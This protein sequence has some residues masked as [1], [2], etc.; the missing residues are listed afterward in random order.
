MSLLAAPVEGVRPRIDRADAGAERGTLAATTAWAG[1]CALVMV[2]PFEALR[3]LVR[4]PG[5]TLTTVEAAMLLVIA[6]WAVAMALA[7]PPG[8]TEWGP[9]VGPAKPGRYVLARPWLA[10]VGAMAIA[11]LAAPAHVAN[12]LHMTGRAA[13]ALVVYLVTV[14]GV[15]SAARRRAVLVSMAAAAG[16]VAALVVGEYAGVDGVVRV[17]SAFRERTA[18]VGAQVRASGPLQYP[19]IASF[20]LEIGFAAV[21]ALVL[22]SADAGRRRAAGAGALLAVLVGQAIVLTFTRA[23]LVTMASTLAIVGAARWRRHGWDRGA[24]VLVVIGLAIAALFLTSR[25]LESLRLRLTTETMD[26]WYRAEIAAPSHVVMQ[27]GGGA[28]V[29]VTLTNIGS[30]TWDSS[31]APPFRFSYHWLLAGE[32]TIVQWDGLRT[33][34][35]VPVAPGASVSLKAAVRAPSVPGDYRLMWDLAQE[36]RLWF[37]TEPGAPIYMSRATVSGPPAGPAEVTRRMAMPRTAVRPGRL[38]LW[39][40]ALAMAAERPVTGVGPDNYRLL[41][42]ERAGL[43]NADTRVHSNNMYLEV[44]AGAGLLG[45]L[46]FGWLALAAASHMAG[47]VRATGIAA[48]APETAAIGAALTAVAVHGLVDSFW[49][50]TPAYVLMAVTLG[51]ASSIPRDHAHRV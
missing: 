24:L 11:A 27:T 33:D 43:V 13:L 12:A 8:P 45:A 2:A 30:A 49:S 32:D 15:T 1:V 50:F 19:T 44:L 16:L 47:A 34:F 48:V 20:V 4:L 37:S 29:P 17:L 42:G 40:A 26:A 22:V 18:L 7:R 23:G 51:L 5:Q 31:A 6:A 41:Y 28:V 35:P 14:N 21:L 25:S 46:A 36:H 9:D 39:R 38:V 10:L 3:P